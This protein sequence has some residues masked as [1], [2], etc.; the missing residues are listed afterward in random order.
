MDVLSHAN[1]PKAA[2]FSLSGLTLSKDEEALFKEANPFGFILFGR[3]CEN[4]EQ[5]HALTDRLREVT[6]REDV[7]ILID[8]EGGRVQR[9]KPPVWHQYPPMKKFGDEAE[10]SL[11]SAVADLRYLMIRLCKDLHDVGVNAN[12]APVMDVLN[13]AT[14]DV[15]GDRA[16]SD[17]PDIVARLGLCACHAMISA[18]VQPIMKHIPGHGRG[19]ADSHLELP[20][21]DTPLAELE[22]TDFAPFREVAQSNIGARVWAMMAHITYSAIDP[23]HVATCSPQV[24]QGVI[25][26]SIGFDGLLMGD[27]LDMKALDRY[28][29]ITRRAE[30]SLEAGCDVVLYCSGKLEDMDK[31]ANVV[32]AMRG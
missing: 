21:V 24:I 23:D 22:M 25:R 19:N 29:D 5:L 32:P 10:Q 30:L 11:D 8:Q 15:I 17:D 1:A 16:F 4:R 18:G 12:C 14:H 6:G 20:V 27:D 31:L 7:P 13:A 28:G 3:N 9:L 26:G 2:I